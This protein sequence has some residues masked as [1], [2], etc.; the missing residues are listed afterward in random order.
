MKFLSR[1]NE[2]YKLFNRQAD[3]LIEISNILM[4]SVRSLKDPEKLR[5]RFK[6]AEHEADITTHEI[7]DK[8]NRTFVTPM[9]REDIHSLAQAMDDVVDWIYVSATKA[10]LYKITQPTEEMKNLAEIIHRMVHE[11]H[12]A[13]GMLKSIKSPKR[14]LNHCI[15][16]NTLE[17]E[18]D[19]A[20]LSVLEKLVDNRQDFFEFFKWKEIYESLEVATDKCEDVANIIESIVLKSI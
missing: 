11:I 18:A 10:L 7:I 8:L 6:E 12:K 17:N 14:L 4:D 1:D 3:D 13:I 15:E 9:D 2:F 5:A 20:L 16:I 19:A